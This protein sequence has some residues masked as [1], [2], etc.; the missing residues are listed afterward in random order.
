[1]EVGIQ[2]L[3]ERSRVKEQI[4]ALEDII[5]L[6]AHNNSVGRQVH[7][8]L[9]FGLTQLGFPYVLKMVLGDSRSLGF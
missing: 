2:C 5:N 8:K 7:R 1:M 6:S 4:V 9:A 3:R